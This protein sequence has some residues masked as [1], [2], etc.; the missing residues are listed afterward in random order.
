[1]SVATCKHGT[2]AFQPC[3]D[4]DDE[5]DKLTIIAERDRLRAELAT[6]A[7]EFRRAVDALVTLRAEL[8]EARKPDCR[9]CQYFYQPLG[10]DTRLC[11]MSSRIG[12]CEGGSHYAATFDATPV[13]LY[14]KESIAHESAATATRLWGGDAH[15]M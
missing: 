9:H 10:T 11:S 15:E 3:R 5:T 1:M 12:V 6:T 2:P 14:E 7:E 8:T 13:R 4:C